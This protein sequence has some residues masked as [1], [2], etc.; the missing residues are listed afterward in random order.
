[1]A[2]Q[3][4]PMLRPA[5]KSQPEE[6]KAAERAMNAPPAS[7]TLAAVLAMVPCER[8]KR[9]TTKRLIMRPPLVEAMNTDLESDSMWNTRT[10][11]SMPKVVTRVSRTPTGRERHNSLRKVR[12]VEARRSGRP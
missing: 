8:S 1:M 3:K 12:R 7:W 10:A 4:R 2:M 9:G 11:M 6:G 5:T